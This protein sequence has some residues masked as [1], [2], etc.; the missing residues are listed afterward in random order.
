[1]IRIVFRFFALCVM[2]TVP[3]AFF[4][5]YI[6]KTIDENDVLEN[7]QENTSGKFLYL[8]NY[9][10]NY[11]P[12][13]W[14][15]IIN[16][17]RPQDASVV[18]VLPINSLPLD[19]KQITQIKEGKLV[20]LYTKAKDYF[21][22]VIYRRIANTEYVYQEF[23]DFSD[24][25]KGRRF[26]GWPPVIIMQE[27]KNIAEVQWQKVLPTLSRKY[28]IPLSIYELKDLKLTEQQKKQLLADKWFF[29]LSENFI[30]QAE[31]IYVPMTLSNKILVFG[32]MRRNLFRTNMEYVLFAAALVALEL[33]VF[34][35]AML[36]VRTLEKINLLAHDYGQGKFTSR[37]QVSKSSILFPLFSNLQLM[38]NRIKNLL[39]SHK[40]LT[41]SI[42][43]EL[44]TPISRL[45]FSLAILK[46]DNKNDELLPHLDSMEEDILELEEL[47]AEILN[48][49]QL[50]RLDAKYEM[51]KCNLYEL[52]NTAITHFNK[53]IHT[54][55]LITHISNNV[56]SISVY[57][58]KK[59]IL[60][61][62]QNLLQN[63]EKFACS[64]IK[65][66][67]I[68]VNSAYCQLIIEDD[69]PGISAED[70]GRV[71]EP[72][73]QLTPQSKNVSRGYGLGLAIAKKI[74]DLHHWKITLAE[75]K[76]GGLQ[77]ILEIK[78][79]DDKMS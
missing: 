13:Q 20:Y 66:S 24:A 42:S 60:R 9:L 53:G 63:A 8:D 33:I 11:P 48:Y 54:K 22:A 65:I 10:K 74:I 17:M 35:L 44:R 62:L 34:M 41:N 52:L 40:E 45:S 29:D 2:L 36:F 75:S 1:M 56:D 55:K 71:F 77:I 5:F 59:H 18:N 6:Y 31:W 19:K 30:T 3:V 32:P 49:A 78:L 50:D 79:N 28:K 21:P 67:C 39:A 51:T 57:A 76:L 14:Q 73:V 4:V 12:Q 61:A 58:N 26:F 68:E 16:K 23:M 46:E 70:R 38:G 69:G 37:T 72:F 47:V 15:Q 43:H 27:L 25:E 64:V 7:I